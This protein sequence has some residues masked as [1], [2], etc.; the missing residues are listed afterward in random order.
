MGSSVFFYV[1]IRRKIHL[2]TILSQRKGVE[3]KKDVYYSWK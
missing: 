3:N 1:Y 2:H